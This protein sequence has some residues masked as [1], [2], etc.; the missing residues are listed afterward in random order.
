MVGDYETAWQLYEHRW[1]S[2]TSFKKTRLWQATVAWAK[3]LNG[4]QYFHSE[5]GLGDSYNSVVISKI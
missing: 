4:K 1:D 3:S 5:Q 2:Q